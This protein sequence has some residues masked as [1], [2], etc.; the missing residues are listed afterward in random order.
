[1]KLNK[2]IVSG[3]TLDIDFQYLVKNYFRN[4]RRLM[5]QKEKLRPELKQNL[6]WIE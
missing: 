6:R 3:R 2:K 4:C 1:M 5:Q